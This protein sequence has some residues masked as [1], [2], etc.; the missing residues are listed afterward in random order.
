MPAPE[1]LNTQRCVTCH[2]VIGGEYCS[3]CGEK[4]IGQKDY[5][6]KAFFKH[7]FGEITNIDAKFYQ[8]FKLL[9]FKPGFLTQEYLAG[10]RKPYLKPVQMFLI[11]NIIYFL[12]QPFTIYTGYNTT[13]KLQMEQQIYSAIFSIDEIVET[14][15]NR[16][17]VPFKEYEILF[18][19]K[20]SIYAKTL[21]IIMIPFLALILRVFFGGPKKYFVEHLV[22]STH[23]YTWNILFMASL[24]LFFY[25]FILRDLQ[26]LFPS[27]AWLFGEHPNDIFIITYLYFA[28]R[29]FYKQGK[30]L[31]FLKSFFLYFLILVIIY[32]Y[33]FML[34]WITYISI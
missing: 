2:A 12:I 17:D 23:F 3:N 10:R 21:L 14:R 27:I 1:F 22:F 26:S 29:R 13:L 8:S 9:F 11:A 7:A 19:N 18:N 24:F 31:S 32:I 6:V 25:Q 20:S 5:S 34:F 15:V 30:F 4:Q 28:T 16:L 33:R